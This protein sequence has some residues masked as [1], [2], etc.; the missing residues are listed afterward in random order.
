MRRDSGGEGR[1]DYSILVLDA[2]VLALAA[3]IMLGT[4]AAYARRTRDDTLG[5]TS[6]L[7]TEWR[8]L[9]ELKAST[10]QA[11][12]DKDRQLSDLRARYRSLAAQGASARDLASLG[13]AI[14]EAEAG[15]AALLS[16]RL[17]AY[18]DAPA[19][20]PAA[21][22]AVP[23][24]PAAASAPVAS[25]MSSPSPGELVRRKVDGLEAALDESEER[26]AAAEREL[27]ALHAAWAL[28]FA[29]RDEATAPASSTPAAPAA[30]VPSGPPP[31]LAG[32]AAERERL[33][34]A[35]SPIGIP[36]LKTRAVLRAI[37]RSPAIRADYPELLDALDRYLTL[38]GE[39]AFTRGRLSA[40]DE[41]L[42]L[43]A[44]TDPAK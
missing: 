34:A 25:V 21:I 18:D 15:R 3:A 14:A 44:T 22:A 37:V 13:A 27:A 43:F 41:I 23:A 36:E 26:A 28:E 42:G 24:A 12:A 9:Q 5:S 32:I 11:L 29:S 6:F 16:V 10:D 17:K 31:S 2:A 20:A 1:S 33:A 19:S 4:G 40:Y 39:D 38:V 35:G 8:L 30:P 7:T